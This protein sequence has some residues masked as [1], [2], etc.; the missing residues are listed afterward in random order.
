MQLLW[1]LYC[2]F[3]V[4]VMPCPVYLKASQSYR[5]Y[6]CYSVFVTLVVLPQEPSSIPILFQTQ[7]QVRIQHVKLL[8]TV[9]VLQLFLWVNVGEICE[10]YVRV[11]LIPLC[12]RIWLRAE[13]TVIS[14]LGDQSSTHAVIFSGALWPF[15]PQLF[16]SFLPSLW[17]NM[18]YFLSHQVW[19]PSPFQVQ[20]SCEK[21]GCVRTFFRQSNCLH[22]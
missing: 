9:N 15:M 14:S 17:L 4:T 11:V 13:Q 3:F 6:L 8:W 10:I 12:S 22:L 7:E 20:D 16:A 1:L 5:G 19:L 21:V 18:V 2:L